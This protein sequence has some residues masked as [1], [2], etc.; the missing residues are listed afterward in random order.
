MVIEGCFPRVSHQRAFSEEGCVGN[1]IHLSFDVGDFE[2]EDVEV[3]LAGGTL[4]VN[5]RRREKFEKEAQVRSR[6]LLSP[7]AG[8]R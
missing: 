6:F 8:Y 7:V 5:G 1:K 4:S 2:P 3:K